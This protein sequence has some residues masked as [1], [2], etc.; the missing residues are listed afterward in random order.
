MPDQLETIVQR[1]ID[2]GEP[3]ENIAAVIR[4]MK[5]QAPAPPPV[6][7]QQLA[8]QG[9]S[10]MRA[11]KGQAFKQTL[12]AA[13]ENP[14]ATGAM[15]AG[16]AAAPF[17]GGLSLGPAMAAE[18]GIGVGGALAGHGVKAAAT[19]ELPSAGE[20]GRDVLTQG[21]IGA[22][23]PLA[24][25]TLRGMGNV[26]YRGAAL[27]VKQF[28]KYGNLV[29][30]GLD[31]GVPISASG[32]K[33]VEGM[34]AE[35]K[36]A[37]ASALAD[38]DQRVVFR[39]KAIADD[40]A[41]ALAKDSVAEMR[42][43]NPSPAKQYGARLQRF[44]AANPD[45]TLTPSA[46]DSVKATL[47][48][49]TGL[50]YRKIRA[51]EPLTAAE[52]GKMELSH[53]ASRAEESAIP[54]YRQL[55]RDKMDAEGLRRMVD[56]RINPVAGGGNQGLENAM[57]IIGGLHSLP[58]RVAMLPQVLSRAAIATDR[59]GR[60]VQPHGANAIR[61]MLATLLTGAQEGQQ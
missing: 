49:Q 17:T 19:R 53:A 39:A 43:G 21:A 8:A 27:P 48:N 35:A 51:K 54:N 55:N 2:A 29:Q 33:K 38:A 41:D 23:G 50:G 52:R 45:G 61:A 6:T 22:G 18:A 10:A 9:P 26:L 3:E 40:T 24:G 60:V 44:Q 25:A 15:I 4:H 13:K 37:K 5:A 31:A 7:M 32:L 20:V 16:A 12:Q 42:A 30:K 34:A 46:L 59:A 36:A 58:A 1:M 14:G 57:V 47:D 28:L 11:T 56:R